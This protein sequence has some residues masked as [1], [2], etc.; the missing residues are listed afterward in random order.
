MKHLLTA[1]LF[2]AASPL[3]IAAPPPPPP[4]VIPDAG[5]ILRQ[6]QPVVPLP[7]SSSATGLTIE[8]ESGTQMPQTRSF[9]L[10]S[11]QIVGNTAFDT[12]TLHTL[13]ADAEGT[14]LTLVQLHERV[15]RITDYYQRHGYP[16]ARAIIPQQVIDA[17][18][19]RIEIIEARYGKISLE[20]TSRVHDSLLLSTLSPLQGG[21]A[22]GQRAL[23]HALLLLSDVPGAV[24]NGTL[25]PGEAVGTSD[26]VVNTSPG[27]TVAGNMAVDNFGNRYTGR[28]RLGGDV[29]FIDP[30]HLGDVLSVSGLTSG[31]DMNYGRVAYESVLSGEG[32]RLGVSYSALHYRLGDPLSSLDAHGTAQVESIWLKHPLVRSADWN[33]YG[34]FQYDHLKLDDHID[35]SAIKTDRHL[36]DGV[37]S[38][39]GDARDTWLSGGVT[40]WNVSFTSGA[41]GFDNG[42][43]QAADAA[44]VQT[45]GHYVKWNASVYHLQNLSATTT[46]YLAWSGQWANE[47]LDS[48]QQMIAGGPHTVRAYDMGTVSGDTGN[49]ETAEIRRDLGSAWQGRWQA[50]AFIDSEQLTINKHQFVA[51]TNSVT[52]SGVGLGLRWAGPA[53]WVAQT[54]LATHMGPTPSLVESPT[55]V[56]LWVEII[57]GF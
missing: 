43:A 9:Q 50:L 17:G 38:L 13:V 2:A 10:K 47:N 32:T 31:G 18:I 15:A 23:D 45:E 44:T 22:I 27:A 52:L 46:L 55:S 49:L 4:P 19:V 21:Q 42:V 51:G 41:V 12:E 30:L 25:K 16:L 56:R 39:I 37:I 33:L 8:Q 29:N 11:I 14:S 28:A 3:A 35:A 48:S 20:N 24:V 53:Q 6:V 54:Y 1:L 57:K 40:S 5:S 7:P 36:D 34:Q 26:L